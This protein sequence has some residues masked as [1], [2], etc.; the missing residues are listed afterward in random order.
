ML[1]HTKY[2]QKLFLQLKKKI[3]KEEKA[4]PLFMRQ[5]GE[6][7]RGKIGEPSEGQ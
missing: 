2:T 7:K 5:L 1:L 3:M 6:N 4:K